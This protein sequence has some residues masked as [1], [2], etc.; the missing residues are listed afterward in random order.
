VINF[1]KIKKVKF[2]QQCVRQAYDHIR[3]AGRKR[4]EGVVL[5]AGRLEEQNSE[6]FCVEETIVPKQL[7]MSL[8]EGLLYAVDGEELHRINVHLHEH[9]MMLI[10]QLHSHPGMAYHSQTD[11]DYAI[12]TKT[13]GL[14][15]VVPNFGTDDIDISHW[16]VYRLDKNEWV[17]L[18]TEDA[19]QLIELI[20]I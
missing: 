3:L 15:I 1:E 7:S 8:E 17:E 20:E 19:D 13:G 14:S 6:T 2:P 16:A 5:F 10:A 12:I 9:K 18:S 4:L 11:D